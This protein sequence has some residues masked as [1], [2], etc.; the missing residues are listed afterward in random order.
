MTDASMT[1][2]QQRYT[3]VAIFLHWTIALAILG[4]LVLG[5]T[6]NAVAPGPGSP[7]IALI[8]LHK[9]IGITILM[10]SVARI[11]WRLM[12]P[13]PPEPPMPGWQKMLSSAVHFLFYVLMIV[14]PLTGWIMA[15][16]SSDFPTRFFYMFD[17][18]LPVLPDLPA[19]DR[20]GIEDAFDFVHGN[21][22]WV[23]IGLIALHLAGALKHQVV[24][25]DGLIARM[26]PGLA[27]P[28]AAPPS[29]GRGA[30]WAF[31]AA[32]LAFAV[33]VGATLTRP[34]VTPVDIAE[35]EP[36]VTEPASQQTDPTPAT[37]TSATATPSEQ[38]SSATSST[39][40][41]RSAPTAPS[42]T[43]VT[44]AP[45]P[46]TPAG[47]APDWKV[48][49]ARSSIKF[50]MAYKDRPF[51][52]RF[53]KFEA[54]IQFDPARPEATRARVTIPTAD[55][56]AGDPYFTESVVEGDWLDVGKH[57][58]AVFEIADGAKKT[59]DTAYEATGSLTIKGKKHSVRLPFTVD[60]SGTTAK[61]HAE[62]TLKR[63]ALGIGGETGATQAQGEEK[64]KAKGQDAAQAEWVRD[65]VVVVI[66]VVASRQ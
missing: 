44:P 26:A 17:I 64:A 61:M 46:Q 63:L 3:S 27:G 15:S 43:A 22:A 57:P 53:P 59:G 51:E 62:T 39:S 23:M 20:R 6:M 21:L 8:Q 45:A 65:D 56:D 25:K 37:V 9:S 50:R 40:S 48:D 47:P 10:L 11:V 12:N 28:A 66:D 54:T 30:V 35:A 58:R 60:I 18:R 13:P 41:A 7:K 1:P 4:M 32:G 19:A 52:G 55:I 49:A 36:V 24:D 5:F 38:A 31:G 2:V 34:A 16:A 42:S 14:M 29:K 33:A